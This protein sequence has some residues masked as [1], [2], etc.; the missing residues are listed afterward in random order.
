MPLLL[1]LRV[2]IIRET[3]N[4]DVYGGAVVTGTVIYQDELSRVDY[5]MPSVA[6][7][8]SVG[9]ETEKAY[10]FFFHV[11]WQ[12]TL[13]IR[14]NDVVQIKSPIY[15]P[16]YNNRFRI[17]GISREANHPGSPYGVIECTCTR[18]ERSRGNDTN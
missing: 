18:I 10:T 6:L 15:H 17:R 5:Y 11:H 8:K 3:S 14:E 2:D 9:I 13:N 4:D 1:N 16:D 7:L 12:H